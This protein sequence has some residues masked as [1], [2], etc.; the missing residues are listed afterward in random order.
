MVRF[1]LEPE[2]LLLPGPVRSHPAMANGHSWF[3]AWLE[4]L[5]DPSTPAPLRDMLLT[6]PA[7]AWFARGAM[8]PPPLMTNDFGFPKVG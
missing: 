3:A 7:G 1:I 4:V 5:L 8:K 6:V 2:N